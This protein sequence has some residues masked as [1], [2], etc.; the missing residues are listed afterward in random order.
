[1]VDSLAQDLTYTVRQLRQSKG[2]AL[3]AVLTLALGIGA[4]TA[5]YQALDAVV[6]RPLP[7]PD[8]DRLMQ[9][10][11]WDNGKTLD[12]SYP[13][14]RE[15]AARQRV[16]TGL[17]AN[18]LFPLH[19]A[20]LRGRGAP[21][22][23]SGA[24]V[25]GNYFQVMGVRARLGRAITEEDDCLGATPAAVISDAFWRREFAA[26]ANALG[27]TLNINRATVTIVGVAPKG[28]YGDTL[29]VSP[30]VWLPLGNQ[31]LVAKAN[32]LN[33]PNSAWIS[34]MARLAKGA[35]REK[36]QAGL[37]ALYHQLT[38]GESAGRRLVLAPGDRGFIGV[39]DRLRDPL[40]LALII[41]GIVLLTA[42][43]NLANLLLSRGMARV[44]EIGV[45]L[46]LGAPRRRL[47]RQL[48]T[49]SLVLAGLGCAAGLVLAQ[50]IWHAFRVWIWSEVGGEG[51]I[52]AG[53]GWHVVLFAFAVG[54][55]VT[56][57][58][59][60]A[61]ALAATRID[62]YSALRASRRS[63]TGGRRSQWLGKTLVFTQIAASLL[64]L[65]G[66]AV[67]TRTLWN[68][69]YQDLGFRSDH[70]VLAQ[71]PWEFTEHA[72]Q[73]DKPLFGP[74]D[75]RM[76]SL[77]G[78]VAA[79]LCGFGPLGDNQFTG[80]VAAP[81]RPPE[82]SDNNRV[83][84]V[85]TRY[86]ET[87]GIPMV[88]GRG[89][90]PDDR[91]GSPQVV[92]LS[93][94]AARRIFGGANPIGRLVS[95]SNSY[96]AKSALQVVG[97]V[98]DVRFTGPRDPFGFL[99]YVPLAQTPSPVTQVLVRTAGDPAPMVNTVRAALKDVA[100]DRDIGDIDVVSEMVDD[101][102]WSEW[103][104]STL[105]VC[106]GVLAMLLTA[107]GVYGVVAYAVARR[108]QEIGIRLALGAA[109]GEVTG[110]L[111][112][113]LAG[114]VSGGVLLGIAGAAVTQRLMRDMLFGISTNDYSMLLAATAVLL[115]CAALAGY[116]PA[117]RAAR[118]DPMDALRQE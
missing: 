44:H 65:A 39:Q 108:T 56:C 87:M 109:R 58:F 45:R 83:V 60:L 25:S 15:M 71:L 20:V 59:G 82:R 75:Q 68:L 92:V 6:Y 88:A 62:V 95:Q 89:F 49:E 73:R 69:R 17:A 40:L 94:T 110:L 3:A 70:L 91:E 27:Q 53:L 84:F 42:C 107:V 11:L 93:E 37:G 118:L 10:Q 34:V 38:E 36:A 52:A 18:S 19:A 9:V 8:P 116:I 79:A 2:F 33:E 77:P 100:P 51:D 81:G 47:V 57:L 43:C 32:L 96:E 98:R 106:F 1:M 117:R 24:L 99:L 115:A 21:K 61:P 54:A 103:L 78:V 7:V 12:F 50:W 85:S 90:T 41:L 63:H 64:L 28:F 97:V 74:L 48:I 66:A 35:S 111:M 46:A 5:V 101:K 16:A 14:Y 23:I 29:G 86:F 22:T 4:N 76:N 31:P 102:L 104:A 114:L 26:R 67:L 55:L 13:L 105:A 112:K 30:D 72:M 80:P 113:E